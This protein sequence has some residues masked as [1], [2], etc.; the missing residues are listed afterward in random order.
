MTALAENQRPG[1]QALADAE[2]R[3]NALA[4]RYGH[5]KAEALLRVMIEHEFPGR[6][7]LV[8]SFGAEAAVLLDLVARID[9][10]VPVIFLE[11]GK[12]FHQTLTYRDILVARLGLSDVRSIEPARYDMAGH[13]PDGTLWRRNPNLCCYL[14]KVLPL[15]RALAGFDAWIGGQKRHHGDTRAVLPTIEAVDARVKINPLADW[16]EARIARAFAE[17]GLPKHPLAD[18]GYASIGCA[19][20]TAP[21]SSDGNLRAGRWA[22]LDKT[23]CGIHNAR[24]ARPSPASQD[25]SCQE[26]SG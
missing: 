6:I 10:A 2:A 8:S 17:R 24:W 25:T 9:P 4:A 13:D 23:E 18:K 7:A 11:T 20:C 1:P 22:G 16:N 5:L 12:H 26:P 19:P 14:R 3:A 21:L 15:E